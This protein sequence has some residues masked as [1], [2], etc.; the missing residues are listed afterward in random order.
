[1]S[2]YDVVITGSGLGGLLCGYILSK[3]GYKVCIIEKNE[4][5]GG[6]LQTFVRKGCVF[7]TGMHYIGSLNEGQI[8]NRFFRYF[9][10]L[11]KLKLKKLNEDG[12]DVIHFQ[13]KDYKYAQGY[14]NFINT[15]LSYFP[16]EKQALIKYT[17]K[18]KNLYLRVLKLKGEIEIL[19]KQN[20][21]YID[22]S[23]EFLDE[24]ISIITGETDSG[25]IYNDRCHFNKSGS[26]SFLTR[27]V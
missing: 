24:M 5:I 20:I 19:R 26:Q 12:F 14:E 3:E 27:E 8:L 1:M 11:D 15:L 25:Y 6:C 17:D 7:D 21:L 2:K 9:N 16:K 10:L 4:R 18:L 23:L 13:N 22:D